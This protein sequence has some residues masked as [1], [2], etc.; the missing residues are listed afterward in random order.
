MEAKEQVA[1]ATAGH[2]NGAALNGYHDSPSAKPVRE[3]LV[4][5]NKTIHQITEDICGVAEQ[6]ATPK[7]WAALLASMLVA[8]AGI[9]A[10]TYTIAVGI[11][12]WGLNNTIGWGW[13]NGFVP[14]PEPEVE[15]GA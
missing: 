10:L 1:T 11:G 5:G 7:F 3:P 8:G 12:V 4:L 2:T 6:K 14:P 15:E 9:G 13:D